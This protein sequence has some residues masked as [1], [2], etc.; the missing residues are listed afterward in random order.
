[1]VSHTAA[2]CAVNGVGKYGN[3]G[4]DQ[5]DCAKRD[6]HW[7]GK[8]EASM[9]KG[10]LGMW[11]RLRGGLAALIL[12]AL[13]AV[14]VSAVVRA[15]S[16]AEFYKGK[17]VTL[18]VGYSPGGGFDARARVVAR[19]MGRHIPGNPEIV[20]Q[21]MPGAGSK[22]LANYLYNAA[23]KDG[24]VFGIINETMATNP[25]FKVPGTEFDALKF[26]WLGSL[27]KDPSICFAWHDS[28][29]ESM[30]DLLTKEFIVGATGTGSTSYILPVTM[31]KFLGTKVKAI[32]GYKGSK[33][34]YLAVEQGEVHGMCGLTWQ[35]LKSIK[36]DW[37]SEGKIRVIGQ[38]GLEKDANLPDVPLM[39]DMAKNADAKAAWQLIFANR[40]M[41][42]PYVAPPGL[43]ED[44]K[45]ALRL[46]FDATMK[47]PEFLSEMKDLGT[48]IDP[49]SGEEI[50]ALLARVYAEPNN[51]VGL[52]IDTLG[53]L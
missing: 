3:T 41:A 1:M 20:V 18:L 17:Q 13:F 8:L 9:R 2:Y 36:S 45:R 29:I 7:S 42:N 33:G 40:Q 49:S 23:P 32:P 11:S 4:P 16:V 48:V 6:F 46:A 21:N 37:I 43:P 38:M 24:S 25:L 52:A 31:N 53:N 15:E 30:D 14:A 22:R 51:V 34:I 5:H 12:A 44:R 35:T 47:D 19:F 28:G 27:L 50:D 39:S 10:N 26:A